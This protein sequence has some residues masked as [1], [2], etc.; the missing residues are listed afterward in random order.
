MFGPGG[1]YGPFGGP[2]ALDFLLSGPLLP[3]VLLIVV[4]YLIFRAARR[5]SS[6][7]GGPGGGAAFLEG[8]SVLAIG[9][10]IAAFIGFGLQA[11]YPAPAS[12]EPPGGEFG[13]FGPPEEMMM[14]GPPPGPPPEVTEAESEESA[15][16]EDAPG[17][18]SPE[19]QQ[20]QEGPPPG[21][22]GPQGPGRPGG[23][24]PE[25]IEARR[26]FGQQIEA[27]RQSFSQ[28]ARVASPVTVVAA[29]ALILTATLL[30]GLRRIP[31]IR[32]GL[33][34]GGVLTLLYG[35]AL[36][37]QAEGDVF[38]FLVVT[39]A[40]LTVLAAVYLRFRPAE[41]ER[42]SAD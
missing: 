12:P 33:A 7:S 34:L 42:A 24:T 15:E 29:A 23:P 14:E 32:D 27:Y 4:A 1:P 11:F 35:L 13:P 25:M 38:R 3:L 8:V 19:P 37:L 36:G 31:T 18:T 20:A 40:L 5:G 10:L 22:F 39:V 41:Q 17:V 6:P 21:Y 2:G 9:L 16:G 26:E 28:Y 30:S